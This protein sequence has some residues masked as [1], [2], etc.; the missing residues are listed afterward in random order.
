VTAHDDDIPTRDLR[1]ASPERSAETRRRLR[2]LFVSD[3]GIVSPDDAAR[4]HRERM[5]SE[6][7]RRRV[8]ERRPSAVA[9]RA[10]LMMVLAERLRSMPFFDALSDDEVRAMHQLIAEAYD[11]GERR[12][13]TKAQTLQRR[14]A[15]LEARRIDAEDRA[16]TAESDRLSRPPLTHAGA[17]TI[18]AQ[19][20][21]LARYMRRSAW[22][23]GEL[24]ARGVRV[25]EPPYAETRLAVVKTPSDDTIA[26]EFIRWVDPS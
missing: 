21:L 12:A 9:A 23:A 26:G 13:E 5:A 16:I 11:A 6:D 24:E 15:E 1:K 22:L 2:D 18:A 7:G 19:Q 8:R 25:P 3:D 10:D 17:E 4:E 20:E 14:I